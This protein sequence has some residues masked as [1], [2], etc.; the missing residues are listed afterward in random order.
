M[1]HEL[2]EIERS[3]YV[4]FFFYVLSHPPR[5]FFAGDKVFLRLWTS[6]L[7]RLWANYLA[8]SD[9]FSV[10]QNRCVN[11]NYFVGHFL[12]GLSFFSLL[13]GWILVDL[14]KPLP[15][16]LKTRFKTKV[17]SLEASSPWPHL[18]RLPV[19]IEKH[20]HNM[21]LP[22]T[23]S[24]SYYYVLRSMSKNSW[25]GQLAFLWKSYSLRLR[26]KS[27]S[28]PTRL[29]RLRDTFVTSSVLA[30]MWRCLTKATGFWK[31]FL[32]DWV[33]K[34]WDI[35]Y[36]VSGIVYRLS[37]IV[38]R[39]GF[40]TWE[41][42]QHGGRKVTKTSVIEFCHRNETLL[43]PSS[44]TLKLI[45]LLRQGLFS[46]PKFDQLELI[47]WPTREPHRAAIFMSRNAKTWNFKR[48]LLHT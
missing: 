33:T 30:F 43:H 32:N 42:H 21:C 44:D 24:C 9:K 46:W 31:S 29:M 3:P 13:T 11:L 7:L 45:L 25:T 23:A 47:F 34:F 41:G 18:A 22:S 35:V 17:W 37:S 4:L 36:R 26:D 28:G 2:L 16:Q 14:W 15:K 19:E 10:Y 8:R 38:Y 27:V 39:L 12:P 48:A 6:Y 40:S 5:V 1:S 20:V